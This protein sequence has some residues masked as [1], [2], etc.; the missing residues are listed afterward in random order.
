MSS[1]ALQMRA[2]TILISN[3]EKRRSFLLGSHSALL[4]MPEKYLQAAQHE[5]RNG[6]RRGARLPKQSDGNE[7]GQELSVPDFAQLGKMIHQSTGWR[8]SRR[9]PLQK[10]G[11]LTLGER[12]KTPY[13]YFE[14]TR[15]ILLRA[16]I[17]CM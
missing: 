9:L 10:K 17:L 3:F 16:G 11:L 14:S 8:R 2:H 7:R 1:F 15:P 12:S 6:N 4:A 5:C 13:V